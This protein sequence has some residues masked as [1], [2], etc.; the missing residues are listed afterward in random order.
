MDLNKIEIAVVEEA[1]ALANKT[2][3]REL[4]ELQLAFVG[5]GIG[6]TAI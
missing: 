2:D 6:D 5:G 1:V 4:S 3:L